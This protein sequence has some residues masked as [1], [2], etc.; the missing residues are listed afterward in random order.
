[1]K[2]LRG[3]RTMKALKTVRSNTSHAERQIIYSDA[4]EASTIDEKR[5]RAITVII[6]M[7]MA[8]RERF[9]VP[10]IPERRATPRIV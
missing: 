2:M 1:M 6:K 10:I 3:E 4:I 8:H 5:P 7:L 9:H